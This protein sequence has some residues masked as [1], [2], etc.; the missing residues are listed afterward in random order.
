MSSTEYPDISKQISQILE[1]KKTGCSK[2]DSKF[3]ESFEKRYPQL[4]EMLYSSDLNM[5]ELDFILNKYDSVR[6]GNQTYEDTSKEVGQ[7]F[8]DNYVAP[9]LPSEKK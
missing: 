6:K 1:E 9:N 3:K 2:E 7:V 5:R 8:Y 4:F